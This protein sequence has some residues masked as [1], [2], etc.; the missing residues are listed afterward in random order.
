MMV[1]AIQAGQ[2]GV[3]DALEHLQELAN[4]DDAGGPTDAE[5]LKFAA[6]HHITPEKAEAYLASSG[7]SRIKNTVTKK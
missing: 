5:V 2:H 7:R 6:E 3:T 1:S 4:G